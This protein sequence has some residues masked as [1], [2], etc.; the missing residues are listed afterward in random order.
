M[1]ALIVFI[2]Q[3]LI[4]RLEEKPDSQSRL[5]LA[6]LH[7]KQFS[8]ELFD[9]TTDILGVQLKVFHIK[10]ETYRILTFGEKIEGYK[11]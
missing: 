9:L 10:D 5:L 6:K 3:K 8:E 2:K 7:R 11:V 1:N 4:R